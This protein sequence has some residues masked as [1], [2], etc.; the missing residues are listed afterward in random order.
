[1]YYVLFD[2]DQFILTVIDK[3]AKHQP[4]HYKYKYKLP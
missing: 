3:L 4:T 2:F 1:M